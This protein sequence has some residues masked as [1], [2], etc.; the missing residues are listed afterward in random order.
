MKI[1]EGRVLSVKEQNTAVVEITRRKSH[2]L[3]KKL[4]KVSK[5][6]KADTAGL[7]VEALSR[8]RIKETR[9]FSKDKHFKIVKILEEQK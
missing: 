5:K 4:M 2:P 1:F 8:V 6:Y 7:K 9:P 3:Y